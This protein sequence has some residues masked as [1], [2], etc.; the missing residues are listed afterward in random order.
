MYN[1]TRTLASPRSQPR[2]W[3]TQSPNS[4]I[5]DYFFSSLFFPQLLDTNLNM[6]LGV[7]FEESFRRGETSHTIRIRIGLSRGVTITNVIVRI[8]TVGD[9]DGNLLF[10][11]IF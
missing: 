7:T 6:T 5:Q 10:K 3:M 4:I 1:I 8:T 2:L 9:S 11:S